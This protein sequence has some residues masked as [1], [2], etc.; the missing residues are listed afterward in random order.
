MARVKGTLL[1]DFVKSIKADK[2]GAYRS[3]LSAQDQEIL[4]QRILA[5]MWYPF[6][7]YKNCFQAVVQVQAKG[8]LNMVRKWGRTYAE[9][10]LK[11]VYKNIVVENNPR[12]LF[13]KMALVRK[14][15]FD[16]GDFE[17]DWMAGKKVRMRIK[18]FDPDFEF[19]Y[20]LLRGWYEKALELGGAK[21]VRS[22]FVAK[23]WKGDPET[24]IELSYD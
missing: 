6:E 13:S 16:F 5:S 22:Q 15:W 1:V 17:E 9:S 8:D 2:S 18:N 3:Y 20:H 21:N 10:I 24:T 7:T 14:L 23:S 11:E 4:S 19:F 12:E